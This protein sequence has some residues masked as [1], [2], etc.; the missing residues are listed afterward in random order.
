VR[1]RE[2]QRRSRNRKKE[3]IEELQERVQQYERQ[4][5]AAT[6]DMQ[7]AARRVTDEN[8]RLR[9]LLARHGVLQDEVESY[10]KSFDNGG[11]SINDPI[12]P[13]QHASEMA[14][15]HSRVTLDA[16]QAP[17]RK[18]WDDQWI[19]NKNT[20]IPPAE[21]RTRE[22]S[23]ISRATEP[24]LIHQIQ[25][26][27][28]PASRP[29]ETHYGTQNDQATDE[30]ECPNTADCFCPPTLKPCTQPSDSGLEISCERAAAIITEM[31]GDVDME[32]LRASLGCAGREECSVRNS[33]VLQI[34]DEG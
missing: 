10:L 24:I 17:L 13:A 30:I 27:A 9:S 26:T 33:T 1:I 15:D 8:L 5:I 2:N 28:T 7:R 29:A 14:A 34:M 16:E 21:N 12:A 19:V 31:R 18:R 23:T 3:L 25:H 4:G 11:A 6:L 20:H 32:T 22:V